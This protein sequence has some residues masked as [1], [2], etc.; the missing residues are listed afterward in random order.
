MRWLFCALVLLGCGDDDSG[1]HG[2]DAAVDAQPS[3]AVT[4]SARP[5]VHDAA[6]LTITVDY[7][8]TMDS[9]VVQ[10]SAGLPTTYNL[11]IMGR[12]G[13]FQL[14]VDARDS[15]DV[16]VGHGSV[17]ASFDQATTTVI[18]DSDFV[19]NSVFAGNQF[20]SNDFEAVGLQLSAVTSGTWTSVFRDDC[21]G[22]PPACDI[23]GRRFDSTGLPV[24]SQLAANSTNQFK[25]TT[26]LTTPGSIPA[27]ASAGT[28]TL[29]FWDYFDTVGTGQ[30]VACRAIDDQLGGGTAAQLSITTESADVVTA[31]PIG[32]G[33]VAVTWQTFATNETIHSL[34]VKPDCT[35]VQGTPVNVSTSASTAGHRR[36]HVAAK[37]GNLLY[38]W[39]NDGSVHARPAMAN[40]TLTGSEVTAVAKTSTFDADHVRVVSYMNDYWIAVR[41]GA[42]DGVSPGK[43]ELYKLDAN[44]AVVGTPTLVTDTS[45]SDFASDKSFG[46]AARADGTMLVVWHACPSGPGSCDV[47]GRLVA[48][49]GVPVANAFVVP[50]NTQ[51]DQVNPS[52]T[53]LADSFV[54]AW[55]DSSVAAPDTSGTAV[56]ATIIQP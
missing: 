12:Q 20:L 39:I 11:P 43:I 27:V 10:L 30:G 22:S 31:A 47:F 25:I 55:T 34:I 21:T 32:N 38:V 51:G 26:T 37:G 2:T 13:A 9:D 29:V 1:G 4:V 50:T 19:V 46:I 14:H 15:A 33:N 8:G 52:V 42:A 18:L 6:R 16:I 28:T 53:A 17:M 41:W 44:G 45:G 54:V 35:T 5:T 49:T 40:G 7:A 56:R 23:F 3:I 48:Q 24:T 36:S